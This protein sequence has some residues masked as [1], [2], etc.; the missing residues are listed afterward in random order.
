[1]ENRTT[2][3][4]FK[5]FKKEAELW[6]SRFGLLNWRVVYEHE[7][8]DPNER[9]L[10]TC[11]SDIPARLATIALNTDWDPEKVTVYQLKRT[12]FHEVME[13]LLSRISYLGECRFLQDEEISEERHDLIRKFENYFYGS[14]N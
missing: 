7:K 14:T 10:A 2:S 12:A 6:I 3:K 5:I 13:L 9:F 11:A 1:M 4:H 8:M